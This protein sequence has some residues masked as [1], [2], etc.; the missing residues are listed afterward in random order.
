[1][2]VERFLAHKPMRTSEIVAEVFLISLLC[3]H[4]SYLLVKAMRMKRE[5]ECVAFV[6]PPNHSWVND[7]MDSYGHLKRR[8]PDMLDA[9]RDAACNRASIE[10]WFT[11]MEAQIQP[12]QLVHLFFFA[13]D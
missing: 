2:V 9:D 3:K 6:E 1:M 8:I 11:Q 7:R 10:S 5:R 4:Y 13:K 12:Q